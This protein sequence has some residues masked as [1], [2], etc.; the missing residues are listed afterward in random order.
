MNTNVQAL[1]KLLDPLDQSDSECDGLTRV[2]H[3][4]LTECS[5]SHRVMSG[6]VSA[7]GRT[8]PIHFWIELTEFPHVVV[9]YRLRMWLGASAPHGVFDLREHPKVV[10]VGEVTELR[11]LPRGIVQML[12]SPALLPTIG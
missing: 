4:V 5:I 12:A 10:Y 8:Q 9:D 1:C 6:H 7:D 2:I 3:Y 11:P